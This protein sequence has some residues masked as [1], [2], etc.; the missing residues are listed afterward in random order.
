MMVGVV[1]VELCLDSHLLVSW[2]KGDFKARDLRMA[3]YL[4]LVHLLQTQFQ[5]MKVN[6]IS[7]GQNTH[8][9]ALSIGSPIPQ[10]ILLESLES[11]SISH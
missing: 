2:L 11:L 6:Q 5:S 8:T 3:D 4:K 9:V 7:K 10:I 1:E